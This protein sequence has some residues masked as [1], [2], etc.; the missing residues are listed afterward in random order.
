MVEC[1]HPRTCA[2]LMS[3][4]DAKC[5]RCYKV[6]PM[7]KALMEQPVARRKAPRRTWARGLS[8]AKRATEARDGISGVR[9]VS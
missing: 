5:D 3:I 6:D 2:M 1:Y 9:P 7:V 8:D 4:L